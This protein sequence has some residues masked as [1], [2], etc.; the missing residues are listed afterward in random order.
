MLRVLQREVSRKRK[1]RGRKHGASKF[2][3]PSSAAVNALT[4]AMMRAQVR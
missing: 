1:K 2:L 4:V 3:P